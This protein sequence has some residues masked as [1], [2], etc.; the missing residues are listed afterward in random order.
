MHLEN[1]MLK[2]SAANN[3]LTLL[4]NSS[5]EANRVD[6]D[7]T[8]PIGAV[9]SGSTLFV[10]EASQTFQQTTFVRF[11]ALRVKLVIVLKFQ[12]LIT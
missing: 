10:I 4:T 1:D 11:G 3:C 7:Q 12:T 6:P 8:A 5:I 2:L 9:R